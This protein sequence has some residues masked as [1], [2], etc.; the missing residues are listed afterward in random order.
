MSSIPDVDSGLNSVLVTGGCGFLGEEVVR[1]FLERGFRV[2]SFDKVS[3][4]YRLD[5]VEYLKGDIRDED[6]VR[7]AVKG[8]SIVVH[9]VAAVPLSKSISEFREVNVDGTRIAL[10]ASNAEG[11]RHFIYI[12][13]SAVYGIPDHNPVEEG[14]SRAPLEDYGRA[15]NEAEDICHA[16]MLESEM[17]VSVVRPRTILGPGRLGIFGVLFDWIADGASVPVLGRGDNVYQFV[18]VTDLAD[19]IAE[20][21]LRSGSH[22]LN[23]GGSSP[24]TMRTALEALCSHAETGART[25]SLS[26]RLFSVV[27]KTTS[28]LRLSPLAPYHW[29]LYGETLYFS[30]SK[31]ERELGWKPRFSSTEALIES[32]DAYTAAPPERSSGIVSPHRSVPKQGFLRIFQGIS[33]LL[34][35]RRK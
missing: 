32:Y 12:S 22:T 9:A 18:H 3:P 35:S 6:A 20:I 7:D 28:A 31:A 25:F 17:E 24:D 34:F 2:R 10:R 8:M 21:S 11:A 23:I 30:G 4:D 1:T 13:S 14:D 5:G 29:L 26:K 15:K 27:A 16:F 19:A 33:K